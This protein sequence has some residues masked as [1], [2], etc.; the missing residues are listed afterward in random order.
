L[1]DI[2]NVSDANTT[3]NVTV[4][5]ILP[6]NEFFEMSLSKIMPELEKA[7]LQV[8]RD[9]MLPD[10]VNLRFQAMDDRCGNVLSIFMA[11]YAY[12][13]C[14]HVLLG[15]S[16]EYALGEY[17]DIFTPLSASPSLRCWYRCWHSQHDKCP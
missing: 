10:N 6:A 7:R 3:C 14:A 12:S 4:G 17:L 15:P 9:N 1:Q 16:C 13:T 2:C 8:I 11:H 5:V